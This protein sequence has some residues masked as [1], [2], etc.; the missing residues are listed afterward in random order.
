[1]TLLLDAGAFLA[2]ERGDREVAALI[3]RELRSGR[4]PA[5]H[6]GVVGQVWRSDRG[7]QANLARLLAGTEVAFL[8]ETLGRRA[9]VVLG[10]A[11]G[12][13]VI[14][15]ALVVLARDG[16]EILTSDP[17]DLRVL[18]EAA[19]LHVDLVAV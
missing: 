9:G 10:R 1:M 17:D 8:D 5:T 18:A 16:D 3:K 2:V 14:D 19:A 7:R 11:H 12:S 4:V 13:D 6:G 15:A